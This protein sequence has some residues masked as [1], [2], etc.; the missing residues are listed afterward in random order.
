MQ[1]TI[2]LRLAPSAAQATALEETTRQFT[3]VFNAV[4]AR[5]WHQ[6]LS[7][8]VKLHHATY[9]PLKSEFPK[10]VSDLHIQAR[11]KAT[12]AIKSALRRHK[13]GRTVSQPHSQRCPPRFNRHTFVLDWEHQT[14]RLSLVGGRTELRFIVPD[15]S[16]KYADCATD[17]A[18][19]LE[20]DGIWWLHVV[21][22]VSAPKVAPS[23]QLVGVDLGLSRPAVLS[24]NRFLG[25]RAWKAHEGRLFKLK[26][27]LQKKGTRSAK[28]HLRKLGHRQMRFR[29]DCDHLLSRRIVEAVEGGA[30]L[31]VENLKELRRRVKTKRKTQIKRRIHSWSFA[32]LK[33]FIEYKAEEQ[34]CMVVAVDPRHTS[35]ACSRCGHTARNNRRSRDLF[36]C[37]R[38]GFTLHADLNGAR[39]IAA[40]YR[41]LGGISALGGLSVNQP[42][43]SDPMLRH[44]G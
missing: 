43:V 38:C 17:T 1:R 23:E 4:C 3:M 35:Q 22:T 19:L 24:T 42:I 18:D 13:N 36:V 40:K 29:R 39:N 7:D 9:Y 5:G 15:Y 14:V 16:A 25:K 2:R 31:V 27:A 8:G 32:Q 33:G 41:A 10:L 6:R 30:T 11:V 21:V 34:G 20:R 28:R 26:R 12:E 44:S 37:R